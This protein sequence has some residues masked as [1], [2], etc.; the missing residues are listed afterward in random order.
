M[1]NK[2][3]LLGMSGGVDSSVSA[4]LLKEQGYEVIGVTFVLWENEDAKKCIDTSSV[5]D[6]KKVC[7]SLGIKH[8]KLDCKKE[9]K[10]HVIDNF[11]NT[12]KECKTPNPCIECNRYLK[13]GVMMDIAKKFGAEY[14]ATGHYALTSY[15]EEYGRYGVKKSKAGKKDQSYVLYNIPKDVVKKAIFPLGEFENKEEI[16]KKAE[17]YNLEVSDKKDSQ[18][19]CFIPDNDYVN[20][21]EKKCNISRKEGNIVTKKGDILGRHEGLYRYTVGQRKG[22]HTSS[23]ERLYVIKLDKEKNELVVGNEVELFSTQVY[24]NNVNLLLVDELTKPMEVKAKIRYLAK[25]ETAIIYPIENGIMKVEFVNP[26]RA[27][28]PGQSIVFYIGDYVLGG[29]KIEEAI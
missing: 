13:F 2:K 9:F 24:V 6:A 11:I 8:Y 20:F 12:Y 5:L 7:D 17:E 15:S 27:V 22:I 14:I 28:T 26:Q 25:E 21:L 19:I 29:G 18:E 3:V 23:N 1:S 16:R 4:I 10:E